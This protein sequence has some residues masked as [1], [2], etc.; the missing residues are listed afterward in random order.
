MTGIEN[1]AWGLGMGIGDMEQ[2]ME[3]GMDGIDLETIIWG[4]TQT[5]L[6]CGF[7]TY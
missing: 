1:E 5:I 2:E 6:E 3:M 7:T 4:V